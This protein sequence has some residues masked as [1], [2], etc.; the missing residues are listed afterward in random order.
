MTTYL[1]KLLLVINRTHSSMFLVSKCPKINNTVYLI[2]NSRLCSVKINF[3]LGLNKAMF[4]SLWGNHGFMSTKKCQMFYKE[5]LINIVLKINQ[6]KKLFICFIILAYWLNYLYV[7]VKVRI[8]INAYVWR[9]KYLF[10]L[11]NLYYVNVF[12]EQKII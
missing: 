2:G 8:M 5:F 11:I 1:Q 9:K 7:I 10:V 4:S 6:S 3:N 12:F